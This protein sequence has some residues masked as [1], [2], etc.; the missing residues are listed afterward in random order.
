LSRIAPI[1]ALL[2]GAANRATI[3]MRRFDIQLAGADADSASNKY[4]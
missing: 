4:G 1:A 3:Q 2:T